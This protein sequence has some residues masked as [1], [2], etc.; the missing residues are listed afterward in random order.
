M[1]KLTLNLQIWFTDRNHINELNCME[2]EMLIIWVQTIFISCFNK[3][4]K[5]FELRTLKI[6]VS[7]GMFTEADV[8]VSAS[9]AK[10]L[11]SVQEVGLRSWTRTWRYRAQMGWSHKKRK[12][13]RPWALSLGLGHGGLNYNTNIMAGT[14]QTTQVAHN[15]WQHMS[16]WS[17]LRRILSSVTDKNV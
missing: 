13:S 11:D 7:D 14:K 9:S 1:L 4:H 3:L 12:W 6:L 16:K 2:T 17:T 15:M 8:V 10:V 5:V